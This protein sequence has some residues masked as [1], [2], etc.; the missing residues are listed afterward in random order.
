MIQKDYIMRMIEQFVDSLASIIRTRIAGKYEQAFEEIQLASQCYLSTDISSLIHYTPQQL[1]DFFREDSSKL[2]TEKGIICADLLQELA[3]ISE[4]KD[5]LNVSL[6]LKILSLNLYLSIIPLDKQFQ[7]EEYMGK[8]TN[9]TDGLDEQ[10]LP[11]EV[12]LNLNQY[13]KFIRLKSV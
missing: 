11:R 12:L 10:L 4:E 1:L 2:D 3:L 9:L 8:I 13:Y 7:T 5:F 6:R